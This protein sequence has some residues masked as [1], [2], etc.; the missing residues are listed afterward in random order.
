LIVVGSLL[1][2]QSRALPR[3]YDEIAPIVGRSPVLDQAH[4]WIVENGE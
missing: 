1:L 4:T 3:H 2:S